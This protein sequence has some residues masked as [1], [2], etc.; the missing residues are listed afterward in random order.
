M[1]E[2][3]GETILVSRM[4]K[5]KLA[6]R[7]QF[8]L[9]PRKFDND[10]DYLL[11]GTRRGSP[12]RSSSRATKQIIR[13]ILRLIIILLAVLL[14]DRITNWRRSQWYSRWFRGRGSV[15]TMQQWRQSYDSLELG[16]AELPVSYR[17]PSG[18]DI[19]TV[20]LGTWKSKSEDVGAAVKV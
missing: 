7:S 14:I 15:K 20:A 19:P 3:G 16:L 6:Y 4:D 10:G 17:L 5:E 1:R 9:A 11:P 18:D 2:P 12:Y 13:N 8:Q